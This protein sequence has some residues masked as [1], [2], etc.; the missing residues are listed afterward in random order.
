VALLLPRLLVLTVA[1]FRV[2]RILEETPSTNEEFR[3]LVDWMKLPL[4]T[5]SAEGSATPPPTPAAASSAPDPALPPQGTACELVVDGSLSRDTI[6]RAVRERFG[7]TTSASHDGTDQ[8]ESAPLP[9]PARGPADRARAVQP[10]V[11]R[12]R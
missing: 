6:D 4:V 10:V 1:E 2:R 7:W 9:G 5:T 11:E 12:K 3:R 8:V